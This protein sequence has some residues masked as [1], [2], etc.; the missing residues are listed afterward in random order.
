MPLSWPC[1]FPRPGRL[2]P[3]E[4][5]N[6]RGLGIIVHDPEPYRTAFQQ[7]QIVPVS[8][9]QFSDYDNPIHVLQKPM[10]IVVGSGTLLGT[11]LLPAMPGVR[12]YLHSYS[13]A[14]RNIATDTATYANFNATFSGN[15]IDFGHLAMVPSA[16]GSYFGSGVVDALADENTA[17]YLSRT[18]DVNTYCRGS[19]YYHTIGTGV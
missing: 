1:L 18:S 13:L 2:P 3:L 6:F 17:V 14:V 8:G 19:L 11:V 9:E 16:A 10:K 4:T 5:K 7:D 15:F 12:Y